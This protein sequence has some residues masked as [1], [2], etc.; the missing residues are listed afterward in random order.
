MTFVKNYFSEKGPLNLCLLGPQ[1]T[2]GKWLQYFSNKQV[3]HNVC[4]EIT[5]INGNSFLCFGFVSESN[6]IVIYCPNGGDPVTIYKDNDKEFERLSASFLIEKNIPILV[7]IS[8]KDKEYTLIQNENKL[9]STFH[10]SFSPKTIGVFMQPGSSQSKSDY[11]EVNFGSLP[12]HN[13]IPKGFFAFSKLEFCFTPNKKERI[14]LSY[15]IYIT[16]L[17]HN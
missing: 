13:E 16:I 3:S 5:W 10:S 14:M 6:H 15:F 4:Y 12:F 8:I 1:D 2:N 11:V 7:C 9:I 17:V